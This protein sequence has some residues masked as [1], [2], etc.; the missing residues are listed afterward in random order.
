MRHLIR[1]SRPRFW[2]YL[3]GPYMVALAAT[4]LRPPLEVWLLGLYLTLPA[5]LLIYGVNDLFDVDTDRLNPKKRDYEHL[6][7]QTQRRG[8]VIA[9]LVLN[10]PFL[11]LVPF[12]P[13]AWPWLLLFL[14]TGI[15]YS[16]PPLRAKA[17]PVVD[18]A[19]NILYVAPGLAAYATV[20]G[21]QPPV[22]VLVAALLWCMAMH[23]YSAVP[24]IMADR[25]ADL[26]TVATYFGRVRT[27]LLCG[28]A[29]LVAAL[30]AFPSV[31]AFA[32]V[33][34]LAYLV[35]IA[36]SLRSRGPEQLFALYRRFPVLNTTLGGALFVVTGLR[37]AT[38]PFA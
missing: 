9:I 4:S 31:G 26:S 5:N 14:V 12:L 36:L 3:L 6:L 19:F 17:R 18:A 28:A 10:V 21:Q 2:M 23:A 27:L 30:L 22:P 34:G 33:G 32:A 7:Q 24:D 1:V 35:M 15:G 20:S 8:L 38:W 25:A 37:N 16:V 29:Y 11:A 13:N